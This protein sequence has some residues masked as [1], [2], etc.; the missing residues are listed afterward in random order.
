MQIL[1]G[2]LVGGKIAQATAS[3]VA[4]AGL[5]GWL[6]IRSY[7]DD[8]RDGLG[9]AYAP[10]WAVFIAGLLLQ[11]PLLGWVLFLKHQGWFDRP[12]PTNFLS[13]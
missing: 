2:S 1:L 6:L 9:N 12:Q 3:F 4:V 11:L 5:G 10:R 13:R 8:L 7:R